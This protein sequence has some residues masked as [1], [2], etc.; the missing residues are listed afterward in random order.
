MPILGLGVYPIDPNKTGQIIF[1]DIQTGYRL[2]ETGVAYENESAVGRAIK[3]SG[4]VCKKLFITTKLL[5]QNTGCV[6]AKKNM[7]KH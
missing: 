2:V 1:E 3:R 4:I 7:K 5:V 6:N